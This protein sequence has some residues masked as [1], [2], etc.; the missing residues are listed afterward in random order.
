MHQLNYLASMAPL[1]MVSMKLNSE[2][3]LR[4]DHSD[5]GRETAREP[6]WATPKTQIPGPTHLASKVEVLWLTDKILVHANAAIVHKVGGAL[7]EILNNVMHIHKRPV[8]RA[9]PLNG[10]PAFLILGTIAC[11]RVPVSPS[12]FCV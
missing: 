1:I 4:L 8:I 12:N 3:N 2:I 5:G 7:V 11:N 10:S 9:I 6:H